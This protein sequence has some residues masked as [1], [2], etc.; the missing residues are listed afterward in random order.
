[1]CYDVFA[2]FGMQAV[3]KQS[4]LLNPL[5]P[6][7]HKDRSQFNKFIKW[8]KNKNY[9]CKNKYLICHSDWIAI[10]KAICWVYRDVSASIDAE[11]SDGSLYAT[12]A[13]GVG[14]LDELTDV[15]G[16]IHCVLTPMTAL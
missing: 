13:L 4:A 6:A 2:S 15:L 1:M 12:S 7:F 10:M 9:L 16:R 3:F 14:E 8:L 5:L 11:D